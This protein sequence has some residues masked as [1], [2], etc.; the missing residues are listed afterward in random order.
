MALTTTDLSPRIGTQVHTDIETLISGKYAEEIRDLAEN[1]GVL[2]FRGLQMDDGQQ[3]AF[4]RTLGPILGE[5]SG[6]VYKVSFDPAESPQFY[7]YT[8]GNFSWHI[9]R[10]DSDVPPFAT[11]L[12][13]KRLAHEG[14]ETEFANTYAAWEDLPEEDKQLIENLRCIHLVESSF[15]EHVRQPSLEMLKAW[16]ANEPKSHPIVWRHRSG[17]KSLILSWSGTYVEGMD[18]QEGAAL[19]GRLM[20][21]ATRPEYVYVHEWQVGDIVLWDNTGTM[22]R[23]RPYP[24]NS[25][26][27]HHRTTV[28]GEEPFDTQ[29]ELAAV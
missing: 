29:Q 6:D 18:T 12:N 1:R 13:S 20:D 17:R 5:K 10:T 11:I 28:L 26:R 2:L 8:P 4:T 21:W 15:R 22:H 3:L 16:R 9:D 27:L 24:D 23:S 25:P 7:F 19:L 14:G